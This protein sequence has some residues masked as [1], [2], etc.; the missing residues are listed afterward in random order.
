MTSLTR[1]GGLIDRLS[2]RSR[3]LSLNG[4][5]LLN[6]CLIGIFAGLAALVAISLIIQTSFTQLED[7]DAQRQIARSQAFF[8]DLQDNLLLRARDWA[9]WDDSNRFINELT[10]QFIVSNI[11]AESFRNASVEGIS[12]V[13]FDGS[14]AYTSYFDQSGQVRPD[15]A[16][17]FEKL[18]TSRQF[19]NLAA[20]GK[21]FHTYL[22]FNQRLFIAAGTT[23][24]P[25]NLQ[26]P[27][28]GY[29]VFLQPVSLDGFDKALQVKGQL[30]LQGGNPLAT[31]VRE[32]NYLYIS[33]PIKAASSQPVAHVSFNIQ[34]DLMVVAGDLKLAIIAALL[35]LGTALIVTLRWRIASLIVQPIAQLSDHVHFIRETGRLAAVPDLFGTREITALQEEFNDLFTELEKLRAENENQSFEIGR[36]QSAVGVM[37]NVRNSLSPIKV[38]L[39]LMTEEIAS[40][41][42]Q[43][44]ERALTELADETTDPERRRRL[45]SYL[46]A[47][48][49]EIVTALDGIAR[50]ATEANRNLA[51]TLEV[52]SGNHKHQ[53][54]TRMD[55]DC[56]VSGLLRDAANIARF[57]DDAVVEVVL[58]CPAALIARGNHLLLRQVFENLITN[59][60]EAIKAGGNSSGSVSIRARTS[61]DGSACEITIR[62]DGEG[63]DP[64]IANR[65]FESGFSTRS[66][67]IGGLGLHWCANTV[68]AMGGS[69]NL[70]S[71]GKG[72]GATAAIR[73]ATPADNQI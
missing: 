37:H 16:Q 50:Y 11:N 5:L 33:I 17:E 69:I 54:V 35:T 59:S 1:T 21:D 61:E 19:R 23:I 18:V 44:L 41:M 22:I 67:K 27:V 70:R 64:E 58:D 55:E 49:R 46:S 63:F 36:T 47:A 31:V 51:E 57:K 30:S 43:N 10:P 20:P 65:L 40:V 15:L 71:E 32:P 53:T 56:D 9:I 8:E 39:S 3:R 6:L 52:I 73:L 29:V 12:F 25:S 66:E 34:R 60:T 28:R 45:I 72:R 7:E 62:D 13:R 24:R 38:I 4:R 2:G 42:P 26:G 48:R 68:N 14:Y